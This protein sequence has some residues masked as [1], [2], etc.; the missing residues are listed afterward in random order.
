MRVAFIYDR[1]N[2]WGGAERILMALHEIWPEAPLYTS[3]Y[4]HQ[5]ALWAK[6][7]PK[8]I[9]S[10]V[11]NFPFAIRHELYASLMPLAFESFTFDDYDVVISVT[12]EAAKGVITKPKTLHIC[13]CLTPTR[14]LWSH[15]TD[16]FRGELFQWLTKPVVAYLREWDKIAGQRPD[17]YLAISENVRERIKKYYGRDSKVIYP[18]TGLATSRQS[19]A[20]SLE[21]KRT[22]RYMLDASGFFLVVSRLVPYKR[23]DIAIK[24]FNELGLSLKVVGIGSE[25]GKLRRMAK[26]NIEFLG[27]L[28][29]DALLRYYQECQALVFPQ[30]EDLGL[31]SIEAQACGKPVVAFRG[32]GALE[33]VIPGKTGEFFYPQTS[34][35]LI[36]TVKI[37]KSSAYQADD[38]RKN[39][40][41]FDKEKFKARFKNIVEKLWHQY[42]KTVMS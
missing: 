33:T 21:D 31:V 18:P 22:R 26:D 1:V 15:Y 2:K 29:D 23:I 30:D 5:T 38:C 32:G 20:I 13:Y 39:A 17:Y 41:I 9:P 28:T 3:V 24:A 19:L 35:A 10:F 37:F 42:L 34:S 11:N 6:V 25:M 14:Y 16:Y 4:N 7:F 40:K 8:V 27:E 12:S 36:E